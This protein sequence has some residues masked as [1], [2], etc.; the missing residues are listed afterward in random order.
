VILE[1]ALR[2]GEGVFAELAGCLKLTQCQEGGGE[3]V[4]DING[5]VT[6]V[7]KYSLGSGKRVRAELP[8]CLMFTKGV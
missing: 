8:R 2:S 6:L 3:F 1:V 4:C 7:T 5:E